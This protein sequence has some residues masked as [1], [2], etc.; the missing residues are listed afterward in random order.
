MISAAV[1]YG[2]G[3]SGYCAPGTIRELWWS[4]YPCYLPLRAGWGERRK[5]LGIGKIVID[6]AQPCPPYAAPPASESGIRPTV[7][8]RGLC[9]VPC[10]LWFLAS[11]HYRFKS[12]HLKSKSCRLALGHF[13]SCDFLLLL[14]SS[15]AIEY[16][17]PRFRYRFVCDFQ[18]S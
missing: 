13:S 10:L 15:T 17:R 7:I 12:N 1:L 16:S 18:A 11:S 14:I 8:S 3:D 6:S 2:L 9:G 5:A 4:Y